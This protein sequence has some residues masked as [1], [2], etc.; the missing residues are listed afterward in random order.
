MQNQVN[1]EKRL[2]KK[3]SGDAAGGSPFIMH[4]ETNNAEGRASPSCP[5]DGN[6]VL[7]PAANGSQTEVSEKEAS[8]SES[9][10]DAD[11][12][13]SESEST[14]KQTTSSRIGCTPGLC[15]DGH[16]Y[17]SA[18]TKM[19]Y[20]KS[21]DSNAEALTNALSKLDFSNTSNES[22][23][24]LYKDP[25]S[26]LMKNLSFPAEKPPLLQTPQS[27]FQ[28][29]SQSYTTS[30]KECS[31]QSCLYQFTSVELLMGNN[32]LLCE[33]CTD[34]KQKQQKKANCTG[35]TLVLNGV[36]YFLHIHI[37]AEDEGLFV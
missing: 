30:S 37:Q 10:I 24:P 35:N 29:L 33:N 12:E 26:S 19:Q 17:V 23:G 11:S 34:R 9:S 3:S 27:A 2:A 8:H 15:T 5:R 22:E 25:A 28:T 31:I 20:S 7:E 6:T 4:E 32:K 1:H 18:A 13:A 14:S 21:S 16:K 36:L